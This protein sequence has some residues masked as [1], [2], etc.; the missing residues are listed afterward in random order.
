MPSVLL[1]THIFL[2]LTANDVRLTPQARQQIEEAEAVFISAAS[3]W[4]VAIKVRLGKL[5]V[6]VSDVIDEIHNNG[7]IELPVTS[8]HAQETTKLPMLHGDPFDRLL[9][10]QAISQGFHLLTADAHLVPYSGLV[11]QV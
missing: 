6:G 10:G 11:V 7:F 9:I 8:R 1:D 2:W 3:V 4:E 5:K